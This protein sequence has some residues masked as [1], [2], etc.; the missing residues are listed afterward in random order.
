MILTEFPAC[1]IGKVAVGFGQTNTA[2]WGIR[3][4]DNKMSV[5][6]IKSH[7]GDALNGMVG[8]AFLSAVTNDQQVNANQALEE[9]GFLSSDWMSKDQHP[10][11][12][13]KLWWF[14]LE[15]K[16]ING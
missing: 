15:D 5:K 1:C 7:I 9:C 6:D 2:D 16:Q 10:E 13:V 12:K 3:P 14:P 8:C 4:D 11:T